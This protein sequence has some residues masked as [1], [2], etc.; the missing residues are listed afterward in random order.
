MGSSVTFSNCMS[1]TFR[2]SCPFA[3]A[4]LP[5]AA[6][7]LVYM[8]SVTAFSWCDTACE[9]KT[10][11]QC[12]KQT[13]CSCTSKTCKPQLFHQFGIRSHLNRCEAVRELYLAHLIDMFIHLAAEI[14]TCLICRVLPWI[15]LGELHQI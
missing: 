14:L 3:W 11:E 7:P 13:V 10:I 9:V 1:R 12:M 6:D 15:L 5:V 2:T 4:G 8:S